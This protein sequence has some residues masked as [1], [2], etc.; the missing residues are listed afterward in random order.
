MD[1]TQIQEK[2]DLLETIIEK[3]INEFENTTQTMIER[4]ELDK[5]EVSVFGEPYR[6][7]MNRVRLHVRM[8]EKL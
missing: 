3:H 8:R 2:K 6:K 7:Y 1:I 4:V 5:I